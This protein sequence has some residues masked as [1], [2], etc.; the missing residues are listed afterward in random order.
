MANH[1]G[2]TKEGNPKVAFTPPASRKTGGIGLKWEMQHSHDSST[3]PSASISSWKKNVFSKS[4]SN[5]QDLAVDDKRGFIPSEVAKD[6]N[7]KELERLQRK[8]IEFEH[9][10]SENDTLQV[11][12]REM[13]EVMKKIQRNKYERDIKILENVKNNKGKSASN[14]QLKEMVL[15]KKKTQQEP[16][17]IIDPETGKKVHTPK[18]IK[19]VSLN[20][21]INLL[22]NKEPLAGY[23]EVVEEK[24]TLHSER[25]N[26]NPPD[27]L[28]ELPMEAFLKACES[29]K[30]KPGK[31]EFFKKAGKSLAPALFNLFQTVWRTES[32]P[33]YWNDSTIIQ[34]EK[35]NSKVGDL[36]GIRHIHD[37]NEWYKF[38]GQIVTHCIKEPIFRNLPRHQ[39]ACRPGH[40][41]AQKAQT[42]SGLTDNM[43]SQPCR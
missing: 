33:K 31:Y 10:P 5:I 21:C 37:K 32:I 6:P 25:M 38:F 34:L 20:Y 8:K 39:I 12:D 18:E 4:H 13:V 15:G 43:H 16:I 22:K 36:D 19:E 3:F 14:F 9:K 35:P 23:E 11:I 28:H 1:N 40:R 27:D 2:A 24:D 26:E 17:V 7:Q 42:S 30:K 29:L 41:P